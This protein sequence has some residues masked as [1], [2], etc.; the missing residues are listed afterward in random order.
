M[1]L[2]TQI[3]TEN[4]TIT[5]QKMTPFILKEIAKGIIIT[6]VISFYKVHTALFIYNNK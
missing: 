4:N 3:I 2:T 5:M 1:Q 6:K